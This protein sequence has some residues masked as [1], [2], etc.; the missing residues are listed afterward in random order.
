MPGR[1]H[2]PS[3]ESAPNRRALDP[4]DTLESPSNISVGSSYP[5]RTPSPHIPTGF[6]WP[7]ELCANASAK[8]SIFRQ[9]ICVQKNWG[10]PPPSPIFCGVDSRKCELEGGPSGVGCLRALHW[11]TWSGH[12]PQSSRAAST[13][14]E[15]SRSAFLHFTY[16]AMPSSPTILLHIALHRGVVGNA[17]VLIFAIGIGTGNSC[18][19]LL[20]PVI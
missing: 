18:Q 16:P 1:P 14:S 19:S 3:K 8:N 10:P 4:K 13:P 15:L 12:W 17:T 7:S 2:H 5:P 20:C 11:G 9:M 6:P